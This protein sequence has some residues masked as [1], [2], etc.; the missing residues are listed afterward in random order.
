MPERLELRDQNQRWCRPEFH[1]EIPHTEN[2]GKHSPGLLQS[3]QREITIMLGLFL[4]VALGRRS[5]QGAP[6]SSS[7]DRIAAR[8]N[9]SIKRR[10]SSRTGCQYC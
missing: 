2:K 3:Q 7:R 6:P 9:D 1:C 10:A 5:K 4:T 8:Q